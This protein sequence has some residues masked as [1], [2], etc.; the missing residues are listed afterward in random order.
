M[1]FAKFSKSAILDPKRGTFPYA[2]KTC[3]CST[4][5]TFPSNILESEIFQ[6]MQKKLTFLKNLALGVFRT[7][8]S[9]VGFL[10]NFA[11][12]SGGGV[13]LYR[14]GGQKVSSREKRGG[15]ILFMRQYG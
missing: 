13:S 7:K 1:F 11:C 4:S 8:D 10:E 3:I 12:S 15:P 9:K 6:K 14:P 2:S 5:R